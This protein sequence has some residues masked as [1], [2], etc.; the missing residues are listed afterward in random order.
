MSKK[1]SKRTNFTKRKHV[2]DPPLYRNSFKDHDRSEC[3]TASRKKHLKVEQKPNNIFIKTRRIK[4]S[5]SNTSL[6]NT[7]DGTWMETQRHSDVISKTR[8]RNEKEK[9]ISGGRKRNIATQSEFE[10][11]KKSQDRMARV[12]TRNVLISARGTPDIDIRLRAMEENKTCNAAT[13]SESQQQTAVEGEGEAKPEEAICTFDEEPGQVP[14]APD[15]SEPP[16]PD[17]TKTPPDDPICTFDE[18]PGA[19]PPVPDQPKSPPQKS[20]SVPSGSGGGSGGGGGGGGGGSGGGG[21]GGGGGG[22]GGEKTPGGGGGVKTPGGGGGEKTPGGGGGVKTPGGG[23][24]IKKTPG[25]GGE[26]TVTTINKTGGETLSKER[27]PEPGP[28]KGGEGETP[29]KPGKGRERGGRCNPEFGM[30]R[31]PCCFEP[32]HSNFD[33]GSRFTAATPQDQSNLQGFEACL[34]QCMKQCHEQFPLFGSQANQPNCNPRDGVTS[35]DPRHRCEPKNDFNSPRH[36]PTYDNGMDPCASRKALKFYNDIDRNNYPR[37]GNADYGEQA[38]DVGRNTAQTFQCDS[39]GDDFEARQAYPYDRR[40]LPHQHYRDQKEF[41]PRLEAYRSNTP[42]YA[43]DGRC[44]DSDPRNGHEYGP[45]TPTYPYQRGPI[46]PGARQVPDPCGPVSPPYWYDKKFADLDPMYIPRNGGREHGGMRNFDRL[47]PNVCTP[48]NGRQY[49]PDEHDEDVTRHRKHRKH[50]AKACPKHS[51]ESSSK[52]SDSK[53]KDVME[54][55]EQINGVINAAYHLYRE[56]VKNSTP[57]TPYQEESVP[58]IAHP[59]KGPRNAVFQLPDKINKNLESQS[60]WKQL[61][62]MTPK[63]SPKQDYHQKKTQEI[64][65]A[66]KNCTI[67]EIRYIFQQN[68]K[69]HSHN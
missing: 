17:Q 60:I 28:E 41:D 2:V 42:A 3:S 16:A 6:N 20:P 69:T 39:R 23:K 66:Q 15:Q 47:N 64:G 30:K 33:K 62:S 55:L 8:E 51:K 34:Q 37:R 4:S 45:M 19:N 38:Q 7:I 49:E 21:S 13:Q 61:E 44:F 9:L 35:N 24:E 11:I 43:Y 58:P 12:S 26:E 63:S 52:S 36:P 67:S 29:K 22:S 27:Q 48:G 25:D 65:D 59:C 46:G 31:R 57:S 53:T 5:E 10:R 14:P 1:P 50:G 18:E 56:V 54:V 68:D 40:G 32:R